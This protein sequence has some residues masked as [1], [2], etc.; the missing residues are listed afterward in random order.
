MLW[1][2][3]RVVLPV[4]SSKS[5]VVSGLTFRSLIHFELILCMELRSDLI[6][7]FYMWLSSFTSIIC[8]RDC[9]SNI[10]SSCLFCHR[11]ID[12]RCMGLFLGL[13]PATLIYVSIFAP[14]PNGT[15]LNSKAFC[16]AKELINKTKRQ[17]TDWERIFA[18][19]VSDK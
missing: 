12:H 15:Y 14:V 3:R 5:F 1:F 6:S 10:V 13:Y 4:F 19:D 7:F 16:T 11:L 9:L 8:W 2:F 17:P 18:S